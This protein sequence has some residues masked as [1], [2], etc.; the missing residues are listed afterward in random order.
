MGMLRQLSHNQSIVEWD[1][2][3][4]LSWLTTSLEILVDYPSNELS[5]KV[6]GSVGPGIL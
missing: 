5:K 3:N 1:K 4:S 2:V 6:L